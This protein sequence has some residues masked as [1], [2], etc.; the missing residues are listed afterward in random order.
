[1]PNYRR[2]LLLLLTLATLVAHIAAQ[3]QEEPIE[4]VPAVLSGLRSNVVEGDV[5]YVRENAKFPIEPNFELKQSDTIRT[6]PNARVELLLQPGNFLRVAA[7]TDCQ[8]INDHYD[9]LK[10]LLTKGSLTF[11]LLKNDWEDTSD[12]FETL[13]QGFELIRIITPTSEVFITQ[14]GIFR[15]NVAEGRTELI[16][17]K[18]EA[19]IDGRRVKEKRAAI[20]LR[21]NVNVA[22][23]DVKA[24]DAFDAWSRERSDKIVEANHSLKKDA[25]WAK[26]KE[27]REAMVDM[28]PS[29]QRGGNNP[30]VVYARPGAV[31]FVEEGVEFS[32]GNKMWQ[33]LTE[34]SQLVPG[35]KLRTGRHSFAELM[36]FPDLYLRMDG[37][38]EVLLEQLSNE[39]IAFKVLRGS[40]I[41]DVARFDRKELPEI[42][43]SG[44]STSV[45]VA[46]EGNYR[47]NARLASDEIVVRRGKVQ[48]QDRSIGGCRVISGANIAECDRKVNDNFDVWSQHRGEGQHFS[49]SVMAT[50]LEQLRRRR[51]RT[52]GFWYQ[53]PANGQYTFV[54]FFST[55]FRSPYGGTYSS[56]LSPRRATMFFND[57]GSFGTGPG[58]RRVGLPVRPIP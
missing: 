15:I 17:R 45:F 18:G 27:G 57:G 4:N 49:G 7:D 8:F 43:M 36:M 46:E 29:E 19:L 16:V 51:F 13:K 47:I 58:P 1:M 40:A 3:E 39:T 38:S 28:P 48:M 33:E 52:T 12:F 54:P 22:D 9:R 24:E 5:A 50:R 10:L 20:S 6:A 14:P 2:T 55:Y 23:V 30:H 37:E 32:S 41:L 53:L 34:K 42:S 25:P 44:P 26:K 21:G 35:D 11:E 31:N 56:A